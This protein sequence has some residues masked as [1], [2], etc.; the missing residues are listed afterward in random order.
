MKNAIILFS[1]CLIAV[2]VWSCKTKQYTLEEYQ[3]PKISF[4]SGGGFTGLYTRYILF[5]NGQIFKKGGNEKEFS[6][7]GNVK[8]NDAAQVFKNY[9]VLKINEIE[10]NDR[11]NMN[12][13]IEYKDKDKTHNINWGGTNQPASDDLKLFYQLLNNL[14]KSASKKD[15]SKS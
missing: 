2:L 4:G 5:E 14:V 1:I 7:F 12:Y 11:G 6:T 9:G 15:A 3:D 13:Y 10:L 8:K